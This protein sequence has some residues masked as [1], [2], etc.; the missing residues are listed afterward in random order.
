MAQKK[1]VKITS[2]IVVWAI[3][4]SFLITNW[5][6]L[7]SARW[8]DLGDTVNAGGITEFLGKNA[9]D[10][11]FF[12]LCAMFLLLWL[13]N[14]QRKARRGNI[15]ENQ[16]STELTKQSEVD[17]EDEFKQGNN[18]DIIINPAFLSMS[19]NIHHR[20]HEDRIPKKTE[21]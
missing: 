14:S 4:L 10:I 9:D 8:Q 20:W 3:F 13:V 19:C 18:V 6:G 15:P 1:F 2:L 5:S 21:T 12:G 7:S 17:V 11:F 16:K